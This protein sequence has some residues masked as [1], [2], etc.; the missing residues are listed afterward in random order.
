MVCLVFISLVNLSYLTWLWLWLCRL[1]FCWCSVL[2]T[3]F[4]APV[5]FSSSEPYSAVFVHRSTRWMIRSIVEN[6]KCLHNFLLLNLIFVQENFSL[7][8]T[9]ADFF[10]ADNLTSQ[11]LLSTCWFNL[12][13][14]KM[15]LTFLVIFR[16]RQ[17]GV[18]TFIFATMA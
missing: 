6:L 2:L 13:I 1:F 18:W 8:V 11:V 10:L 15:T 7:Q 3:S 9:F 5:G 17:L 4:I 12:L 14:I 16:S